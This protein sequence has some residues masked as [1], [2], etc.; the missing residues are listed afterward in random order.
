MQV[1][2][3]CTDIATCPNV[4]WRGG[5]GV[6]SDG[7]TKKCGIGEQLEVSTDGEV[8]L[9]RVVMVSHACNLSHRWVVRGQSFCV[10]CP[11]GTYNLFPNSVCLDCP[12][13]AVCTGGDALAADNGYWQLQVGLPEDPNPSGIDY[14]AITFRPEFYRC[15]SAP[16]VS[17]RCIGASHT[18]SPRAAMV[19]SAVTR[20][21][22]TATA[23]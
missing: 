7:F 2:G 8:G 22:R 4:Y 16:Y 21:A 20:A 11:L 5:G 15:R 13:G 23:L 17:C 9:L 3:G 19:M 12:K 14:G 6:P 1:V 10:R 18:I